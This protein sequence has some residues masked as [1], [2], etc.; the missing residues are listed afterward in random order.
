LPDLIK[1]IETKLTIGLNQNGDI[2]KERYKTSCIH[3]EYGINGIDYARS[4][5]VVFDE[6]DISNIID[7]INLKT[8]KSKND[9]LQP[10]Y[11]FEFGTEKSAGSV[12]LFEEHMNG[13]IEKSSHSKKFGYIIHLQRVYNRDNDL[14]KYIEY[15]NII[16]NVV[17]KLKNVKI[18]F[19]LISIGSESI[20]IFR[21]GKVK[22][23]SS[24]KKTI[25]GIA[26]AK[27]L[28]SIIEELKEQEKNLLTN[29]STL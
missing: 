22:M 16:N 6:K 28:T 1:P 19:F 9:Y 26:S 5:I 13:D 11:I 3:R 4:D 17:D 8:G 15:K 24:R 27:Y 10:Q 25:K 23:Y 12:S 14:R 21:E 20:S 29:A 18:L 7:P 2:S